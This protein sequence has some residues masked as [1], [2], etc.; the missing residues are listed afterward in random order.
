MG[1]HAAAYLSQKKKTVF[2]AISA[3]LREQQNAS[4]TRIDGA[5]DQILSRA[6]QIQR[7]HRAELERMHNTYEHDLAD[8]SL[9]VRKQQL[10]RAETRFLFFIGFHCN[11]AAAEYE[12]NRSTMLKT[13]LRSLCAGW[14][15]W[16]ARVLRQ[17]SAAQLRTAFRH[18]E[19]ETTAQTREEYVCL[20]GAEIVGV[21]V[22]QWL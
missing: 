4:A 18:W 11:F 17:R 7:A 6:E 1:E 5:A 3:A 2:S 10:V 8:L 19:R 16:Q 15:C 21:I 20:T 9:Q 14:P 13:Q 22:G 12:R